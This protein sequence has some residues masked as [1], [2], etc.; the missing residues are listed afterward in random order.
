[1]IL[2]NLLFIA[3]LSLFG[4]L[5]QAQVGHE[6]YDAAWQR[7]DS[8]IDQKGLPKSALEEVNSLYV[9]AKKEK[10]EA[11]AIRALIYR[12]E[13]ETSGQEDAVKK[14]INELQE[15]TAVAQQPARS[16]LEGLLARTYLNYLQNNR[17][18]IY[19]RSK[20]INFKKEDIDSWGA[21]D[22]NRKISELYLGS[23]EEK[24]LLRGI[25]VSAFDPILVPGN[26][27]Y[28][29]PTL[30]DLL[31]HQA[32]DYFKNDEQDLNRPAWAYE[33]DD[34]LVF[35][36]AVTFSSHRFLSTDSLSLHFKALHLFQELVRSHLPDGD[37]RPLLD[38]EIE[39]LRFAYL[40]GVME[41]KDEY[42]RKALAELTDRFPNDPITAEAWYLQALQ[43][44][45]RADHYDPLGDTT[46]RYAN[47]QA[48]AICKKVGAEKDSSEGNAD[49]QILLQKILRQELRL[50]TEKINLPGQPMRSL[51]TWRNIG[52]VHF[53]LLRIDST[54]KKNLGNFYTENYWDQL[55]RL[56]VARAFSQALPETGDHQ[57]HRTEIK[58]DA[59]PPGEWALLASAGQDFAT[60]SNALVVEFFYVSS[61]AYITHNRDLFVLNR[62]SG[63][64]LAGA[65]VQVWNQVYQTGAGYIP[66]RA[67]AYQT[68][69]NGHVHLEPKTNDNTTAG[70]LFD[71]SIPGDRLFTEEYSRNFYRDRTSYPDRADRA[72]YGLHSRRTFFF[73]DRSIYRPGQTLYFKGIITIS[74]PFSRRPKALTEFKTKVMLFNAN[75]EKVDSMMLT[76]N[77]FGS[78]HGSFILPEHQLNGSFT[79]EDYP[80]R[81]QQSFSVEEYKRPNFYVDYDRLKGS[82]RLGDSIRVMGAAKAYAGNNID[83]ALVKYRVQRQ[84]RFPNYWLFR[85][86]EGSF[87]KAQEIAHGE[88][89][90]GAD[91]SFIIP[92]LALPD[93]AINL[94]SDP[95][96]DYTVSSDITDINGET[97]SGTTVVAIGYKSLLLTIDLPEGE[98]LPADSLKTLTVKATN[99]PGEPTPAGIS[100]SIFKLKSADRLIRPRYW[101]E[102]DQFIMDR[103]IY[104]GYFPHDEYSDETKKES[105]ERM[106]EVYHS[107]GPADH[108]EQHY[109]LAGAK[110][111]AGWW[112]VEAKTTDKDGQ[113]VIS[114]QWLELYDAATG[115]PATPQYEWAAGHDKVTEPGEQATVITGS[116]AGDLFVIREIESNSRGRGQDTDRLS[117]YTLNNERKHSAFRVREDD[118]GGFGITDAFVKDNRLYTVTHHVN[119]PWTTKQLSISYTSYRDKTLPGSAE[120][121]QVKISGYKGD[122]VAAE[123]L[124]GMYDASLDQFKSHGW[125]KPN[126]YPVNQGV[127]A[128]NSMNNFQAIAS[129]EKYQNPYPSS[130]YFKEYD[131]LIPDPFRYG[132]LNFRAY[133]L[134]G[135]LSSV[136]AGVRFGAADSSVVARERVMIRG[137]GSD[138]QIMG[139]YMAV[140]DGVVSSASAW[141]GISATDIQSLQVLKGQEAVSLYGAQAVN[142]VVVVVTKKGALKNAQQELQ[143]RKNF[144]ETALFLPD[145]RTDSAGAVTFSFTMPEALTRW[146][147]MILAHT[148]S[149]AFGYSEKSVITQKQLMVQPDAPRFLRQGDRTSLSARIV[150]LSSSKLKGRVELQLT[151]PT[152]NLVV[153]EPFGNTHADRSFDVEAGQSASV[154]FPIEIPVTYNRPLTYRIVAHAALP[155]ER[156]GAGVAGSGA[157]T[158]GAGVASGETVSD[159]EEATLPVL[160]NRM[161]VT[162]SLPLNMHGDG[163]RKFSFDK[164]LQ[165]GSSQSLQ[166]HALTVEFTSNPAWYAVQALPYLMEYPHECAEQTFDRYYANALATMI[167]N[168]SP[169]IAAV[170]EKWKTADTAALL[171][172]L[173]KNQELKSVLLAET[174]WV[175][176]GKSESEQKRNIALLFDMGRMSLGLGSALNKL[177]DMQSSDG[178]F[179]WFKGGPDDRYITQYILTGIGHLQKLGALPAGSAERIKSMVDAAL[180]YLDKKMIDDY[181]ELKKWAAG[182]NGEGGRK[183]PVFLDDLVPGMFQVQYLYMRSLFGDKGI[184]GNVLPAL[185]IYRKQAQH[186]WLKM[187]KYMQGMIALALYRTGDIQTGKNI[188]A[189]LRQNAIRDGSDAGK[190]MYWAG[191]EGGYYWYEAPIEWQ[192]LMIEAFRE[193]GPDA[194]V[195]T[196]LKTWLLRQKQTHNWATTKATADACYA[197]LAGNDPWLS[198]E[199]KV[200]IQLGNQ[201]PVEH[202]GQ[203]VGAEAGTGYFKKVFDGPMVEPSM[204]NITVTLSSVPHSSGAVASPGQKPSARQGPPAWG[205][206]YWQYFENLDRIVPPGGAP[207]PLMLT[208]KLFVEKNTDRGPVLEP[209]N[210]M[211]T[212][213]VGDKIKIRIELRADRDLEYLHMKDMRASCLEPVNVLSQ[214]KWQGGLGYYESTRDAGTDFFFSSLPRGTYVFEYPVFVGQAGN[215]SNGITSIECMY[216]PEFSFH[217]EGIRVNVK[218]N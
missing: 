11:Q 202:P 37:P 141:K 94:E 54:I 39:R 20:T 135:A 86:G 22:L 112:L 140:I 181:D 163:V 26:V 31:A 23:I 153:N 161:L 134:A 80:T 38:L 132:V 106:D 122:K 64:P 96:F 5:L 50:Q 133:K 75:H 45:N 104:L 103:S 100:L 110:L 185:S 97:R 73:T 7:I 197:L 29:R 56:S 208:K 85:R 116:S 32:L 72:N 212:L 4:S 193:I 36:D 166:Q 102:P 27:R 179:P 28:L 34:P 171:S 136:T 87:S 79:I 214:Y 52:S 129:A 114:R 98:R 126:L 35:A 186:S 146:K 165:S 164:L 143:T 158:S 21:E 90:T 178:G 182:M 82:H 175:L 68:D 211:D 92:F 195:D 48:I 15:E 196:D 210:E 207:V 53:R 169:L 123:V 215:F 105:W 111:T 16:I 155:G 3:C 41:N 159:G 190:G 69:A 115:R 194:G 30:F 121:W 18:K 81:D 157:E 206:V 148:E 2:R 149:L 109:N 40:Y 43:Y 12:V 93:R 144:A 131:Q 58:I 33:I 44:A 187:S 63:Q 138:G 113:E 95:V 55:I 49:C 213:K 107:V 76:S 62:Q 168:N 128:W 71:I 130:T 156:A 51:L 172:N 204:G 67:E 184:P 152:T 108:T 61:I 183:N 84:A 120:K 217:S 209:V 200:D 150:N 173:E 203:G 78:F 17:W 218:G 6:D 125:Y 189:S 83:G 91:G 139:E 74:D 59:L 216:A 188:I 142:G 66:V 160:N 47:L 13:L 170:F 198:V 162:E 24:E 180:S 88:T 191:M 201:S 70:Q 42:Y 167:V 199:R 89:R 77:S 124:T 118:R 46:D 205:A 147:W 10:N 177:Q 25:S 127:S 154:S 151:D 176:E 192:S 14:N 57:S 19:N 8:L 65:N 137:V 117:Y 9:A 1:M 119:V 101:E 174:P 99:F 60:D 145:L